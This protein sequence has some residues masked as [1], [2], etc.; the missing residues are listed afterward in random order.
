MNARTPS[1][2]P[3]KNGDRVAADMIEAVE[4]AIQ[5]IAIE[6]SS[7]NPA[8]FHCVL[9]WLKDASAGLRPHVRSL[10]TN[11]V[12]ILEDRHLLQDGRLPYEAWSAMGLAIVED[13]E[14]G[15]HRLKVQSL[16]K[17]V[18]VA[19]YQDPEPVTGGP[20]TEVDS[21][22]IWTKLGITPP[23]GRDE[24]PGGGIGY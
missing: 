15:V 2:I 14:A 8:E 22:N 7:D 6:L 19:P 12:S 9:R 11:V 10:P 16:Y 3:L 21:S 4:G 13:K 5:Q 18:D 23:P 17:L 24:P 20:T 1:K